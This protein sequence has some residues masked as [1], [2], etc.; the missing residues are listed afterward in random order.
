MADTTPFPVEVSFHNMVH[1][2]ALE[3]DVRRHAA[4]LARFRE[5]IVGCRV[6][7]EAPNRHHRNGKLYSVRIDISAPG[8]DIVVTHQGPRDQAHADP[9]VAVRDAFDAA[10]RQLEDR[11]RIDRGEVKTH[12]VPLHGTIRRMLPDYGFIATSDGREIYF[13]RNSVVGGGFDALQPGQAVRLSIVHGESA[14]GP[15][16][17]TVHPVG[18]H[19]LID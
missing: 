3:A 7:V 9:Y 12:E 15:Q 19:H 13:H 18:K 6:V 14:S 10:R 4:K 8:E 17:T 1:A 11:A 2:D 5:R 16:A